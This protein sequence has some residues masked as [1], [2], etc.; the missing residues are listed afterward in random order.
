MTNL[1]ST[2]TPY[3]KLILL[4]IY[5]N[6]KIFS[7]IFYLLLFLHYIWDLILNV[8]LAGL[9]INDFLVSCFTHLLVIWNKMT[10]L[11]VIKFLDF[12]IGSFYWFIQST[13]CRSVENRGTWN[14]KKIKNLRNNFLFSIDNSRR[15]K[16][17]RS[18][19]YWLGN[20]ITIFALLSMESDLECKLGWI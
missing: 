4:L 8:N 14:N 20:F 6:C 19:Q 5:L 1:I 16:K 3:F 18:F 2:Y 17:V 15:D 13:V 9:E 12:S 7:L 10:V 11:L